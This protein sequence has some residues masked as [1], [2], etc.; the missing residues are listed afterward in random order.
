MTTQTKAYDFP[1]SLRWLAGRRTLLSVQGK[2]ELEVATPPEFKG[3]VEGVWS[4]EDLLVG[5]IASCFAVTLLRLAEQPA[6]PLRGLDVNAS[7]HVT[8]PDDGRFFTIG[9]DKLPGARGFGEPIRNTLDIDASAQIV[10]VI[11]H[12][13]GTKV[14]LASGS[15]HG[16]AATTDELLAE[17]RKG[18]QVVNL[19]GGAKL[20]VA[21]PIA[22]G[23]D[24]IAVVG[25]NRKLV[26]FALD[27]LPEMA[28]GQGVTL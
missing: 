23:D 8:Q 3:G 16:F 12:K 17:T 10:A 13:P 18:R 7:G 11:V 21:R 2:D 5:S 28:R 26:V 1:L 15:G 4:P 14:L 27:E 24:H 6:V 9:A 25:D 22:E 20:I 19:K